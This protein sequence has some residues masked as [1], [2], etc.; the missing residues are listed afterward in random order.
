MLDA[1]CTPFPLS[2]CADTYIVL[3]GYSI[4]RGA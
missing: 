1:G 3:K 4:D 2:R